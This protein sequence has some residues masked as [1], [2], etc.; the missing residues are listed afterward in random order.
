MTVFRIPVLVSAPQV[1]ELTLDDVFTLACRPGR[2]ANTTAL[3]DWEVDHHVFEI[4]EVE[5][6]D[7]ETARQIVQRERDEAN[8]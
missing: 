1:G 6:P 7:A 4:R 8:R 5:A 3:D 2:W